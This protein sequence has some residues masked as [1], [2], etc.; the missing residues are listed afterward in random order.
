MVVLD[1]IDIRL[2]DWGRVNGGGGGMAR[3]GGRRRRTG[4][5]VGVVSMKL[6][7]LTLTVL[8]KFSFLK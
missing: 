4:Q 5:I 2:W 7:V 3:A 8:V 1:F 6:I